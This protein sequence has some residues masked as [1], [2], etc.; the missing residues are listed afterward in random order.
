V[1]KYEEKTRE[2]FDKT[3]STYDSRFDGRVAASLYDTVLEKLA[4][5]ECR[6]VLDVGC[7]T[8]AMLSRVSAMGRNMRLCGVDISSEMTRIARKRLGEKAEI[9]TCDIC[10]NQ[11]KYDD[12]SFD[13]IVCMTAFHHFSN[14]RRALAEMHRVARTG[15]R[16][17]I[18]DVTTFFPVR[19]LDN[20]VFYVSGFLP[21]HND[22]DYR[23][24]SKP[25]LCR[26]LETC[27]FQLVRW[28]VVAGPN[29]LHRLFVAT[30]TPVK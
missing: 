13:C 14:P 11:L 9:A 22:G 20:L 1:G 6:S 12:D 5:P 18:A 17:I 19:H 10:S 29:R 4:D 3:A 8:G 15:G 7:G 16:L 21:L 2:Y 27:R 23:L 25:E 24:Y 26:L 28:E 30:A